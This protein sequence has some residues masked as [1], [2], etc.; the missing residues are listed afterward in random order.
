MK[1]V[2]IHS[3][4]PGQFLHLAPAVAQALSA[5]VIF[6][7]QS[8]NPQSLSLSGVRV[9][10]F[11]P[12]R[13]P[14]KEV[15]KYL[16]QLEKAVLNGQAVLRKLLDLRANN[17]EPDLIIAHAGQGFLAYVKSVFPKCKIIAYAE[18][19]F[20]RQN[21]LALSPGLPVDNI[22]N[23][24]TANL[25][26]VQD[27]LQADAIVCPTKWQISQFPNEFLPSIN[28][29]FDGVDTQ[30][31]SNV[32]CSGHLEISGIVGDKSIT[33]DPNSLLLTYGTRGM[34][35]L[36]GFPQFMRAAANAQKK[37]S[38]L[39]VVVFGQDRCVYSE[40]MPH[41]V[42]PSSTG[43]W[44]A[45]LLEELKGML[46][47]SRLHFPGLISYKM[48]SQL[49]KRSNL[50]CYFT[51]PFVVSWGIFEAAASGCPLLIN[52]FYGLDEVFDDP[53]GIT[54]VDLSNQ[55][56]INLS[57]VNQLQASHYEHCSSRLANGKDLQS[58]LKAWIQLIFSVCKISSN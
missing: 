41:I 19:Y 20:K 5:E 38:N 35:P 44:K 2:F 33:I 34:E 16:H 23:A 47:L 24:E 18:W 12:H 17:F 54:T 52:D 29:I 53:C 8:D 27:L 9:E 11:Q 15:H 22:L 25:A 26:L 50:H 58:S 56:D 13:K 32:K 10:R 7:T 39:Q 37:F 48:L 42:C 6:L 55:N 43:S 3:N 1:T 21:L 45:A 51:E 31:F 40:L 4:Y 49:Y 36:R 57:V 30:L 46:D 28:C 14:G